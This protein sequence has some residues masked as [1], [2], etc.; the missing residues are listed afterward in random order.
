MK[1]FKKLFKIKSPSERGKE[2]AISFLASNPNYSKFLENY[3]N[4]LS[5][6][7]FEDDGYDDAYLK[8]LQTSP[9]YDEASKEIYNDE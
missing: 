1:F 8:I 5:C 4:C 6:L 7:A 2:N 9:M 3:K